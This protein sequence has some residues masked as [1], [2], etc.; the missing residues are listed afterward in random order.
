MDE[1]NEEW[2]VLLYNENGKISDFF[3]MFILGKKHLYKHIN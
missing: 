1:G 2:K 3:S